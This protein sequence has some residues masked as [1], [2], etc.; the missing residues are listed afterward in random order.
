M[1]EIQ[2]TSGLPS[3]LPYVLST[4]DKVV[5]GLSVP[6]AGLIGFCST[7][8]CELALTARP[9]ILIPILVGASFAA[10]TPK[11]L[12]RRITRY[13]TASSQARTIV[14]VVAVPIILFFLSAG[15]Q[16]L[17]HRSAPNWNASRDIAI[18]TALFEGTKLAVNW[19]GS[20]MFGS[21]NKIGQ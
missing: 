12:Y 19:I 17:E 9:P 10:I 21:R 7:L 14:F 20:R 18:A 11:L 16:Y 15:I 6:I 8:G 13:Q 1:D 2:Q 5:L 4:G 3:N